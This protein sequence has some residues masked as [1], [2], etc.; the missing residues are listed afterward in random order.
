LT[1]LAAA[2]AAGSWYDISKLPTTAA[3]GAPRVLHAVACL[4]VLPAWT[5]QSCCC[6]RAGV[7]SMY[8]KCCSAQGAARADCCTPRPHCWSAAVVLPGDADAALAG[9]PRRLSGQLQLGSQ[10]HLYMEP[11]TAV[12]TPGEGGSMAVASSCQGCD[13]VRST[14]QQRAV[15]RSSLALSGCV[16]QQSIQ[17]C[18]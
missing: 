6:V 3:R 16:T 15:N 14:A 18:A 9:A 5:G 12:A 17:S 10:R 2:V 7:C 13:Q 8:S 11:Q 4:C 1:T